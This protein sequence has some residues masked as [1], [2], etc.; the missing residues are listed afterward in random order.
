MSPATRKVMFVDYKSFIQNDCEDNADYE[1]H[2]NYHT[3]IPRLKYFSFVN[4][5]V[6]CVCANN[7]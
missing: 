2:E 7:G 4:V 1:K 6:P 3:Q 5:H